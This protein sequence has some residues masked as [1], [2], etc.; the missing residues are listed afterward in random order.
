[1]IQSLYY[2]SQD[3]EMELGNA[4]RDD[5]AKLQARITAG[6]QVMRR[7]ADCDQ[8]M[9]EN[10]A[11]AGA[12]LRAR[13]YHASPG[14]ITS[15]G[16]RAQDSS[17]NWANTP[18]GGAVQGDVPETPAALPP[19]TRTDAVGWLSCERIRMGSRPYW[20]QIVIHT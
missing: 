10:L 9:I 12:G 11:A 3:L 7:F 19:V 6:E 2:W 18:D 15:V 20:R 16:G 5:P 1:L 8:L 13:S 4:G 14:E 17:M